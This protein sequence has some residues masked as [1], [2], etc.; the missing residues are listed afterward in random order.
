MTATDIEFFRQLG[1]DEGRKLIVEDRDEARK[2][3]AAWRRLIELK[4]IRSAAD[5]HKAEGF[6]EVAA[7]E[8][9]EV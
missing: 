9:P 6:C 3:F 8:F 5:M 2:A 4:A 7:V 1:R